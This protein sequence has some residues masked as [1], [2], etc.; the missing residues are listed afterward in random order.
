[1]KEHQEGRAIF[2]ANLSGKDKGPGK[3]KGVFYNPAMEM[4][5]DLHVAFA[6]ELEIEG[7]VLDGLAA[8][9]IRGIRLILE[10]GLNVEFCDTSTLATNTIAENLKING[11]ESTIYNKP[12]EELLQEKKYD[13]IDIDPFGTPAPFL[14]AALKGLND[15][16]ILGV[17][18]TDTAVLCGAKPSICMKR[19]GANS[20]K[21]VAAKEIGIRIML[22]KMHSMASEIGK[23]IQ[24]LLCYSEGHHLRVFVK[25]TKK[26]NVELKWIN[27]DME[28][29]EEEDDGAGGPLWVDKIIEKELVPSNYEGKLGTFFET[30]SEEANGPPGL[31]D[32]NDIARIAEIGQTPQRNKIVKCLKELGHFASS[33]IFSP[34]GIK[35]TASKIERTKAIKLAQSL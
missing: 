32:V 21:K 10:A 24:P 7:I 35:T 31:Y 15:N 14:E 5:R 22:S 33:S 17:S 12:V 28:I 3:A 25:L 9:G 26:S 27:T 13:C 34:L 30:L 20:M 29:V 23:G 16:G 2:K 1:M 11:I 18:A 8:S 4:S 19:Y 6:K